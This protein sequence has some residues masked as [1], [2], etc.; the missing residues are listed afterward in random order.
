MLT[1]FMQSHGNRRGDVQE[2]SEPMASD[3]LVGQRRVD[4]A[5]TA[6]PLRNS[7]ES[8]LVAI[9]SLLLKLTRAESRAFV[10]LVKHNPVTREEL[11]AAISHATEMKIVDVIIYRLR[12][13]L[14][15]HGIKIDTIYGLGYRL[16]KDARD[17][18]RQILAAY[19]EEIIDAVTPPRPGQL[20]TTDNACE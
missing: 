4:R 20:G 8:S 16:H 5:L 11:H 13:K 15:R 3:R 6:P 10:K 1:I 2:M 7:N 9:C 12:K 19:G 17:K 14:S 18:I